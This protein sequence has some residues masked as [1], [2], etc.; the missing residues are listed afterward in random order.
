MFGRPNCQN[1]AVEK[2]RTSTGCPTATS[3]L[4]VYQFRHDRRKKR[5]HVTNRREADKRR[6]T[7]SAGHPQAAAA[8]R[9]GRGL[10]AGSVPLEI[11]DLA[12]VFLGRRPGL[13]GTEIAALAGPGVLLAGVEPVLAG[14]QLT[15]HGP[16][17]YRVEDIHSQH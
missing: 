17:Q 15:D 16:T 9:F 1:G 5:L 10:A 8:R 13:E 7:L 6:H 4:R 14:F 3:T 11:L 12:L 2:T